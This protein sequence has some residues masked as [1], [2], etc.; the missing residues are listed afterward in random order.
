[1]LNLNTHIYASESVDSKEFSIVETFSDGSYLKSVL[2]DDS[3]DTS[4]SARKT[5]TKSGHKVYSYESSSGKTLWTITITG[6]FSYTGS[7]SKCIK[8]EISTTC[9][10]SNWKLSEKKAYTSGASAKATASFKQYKKDVYLQTIT[11]TVTISCNKSG[12]LY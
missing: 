7:S 1:M 6:T 10:A 8:S 9:P 3:A 4:S 2:I 11:R 5:A 12:K